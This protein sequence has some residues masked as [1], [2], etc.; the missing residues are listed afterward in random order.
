MMLLLSF[1]KQLDLQL[2]STEIMG[3]AKFI[4]TPKKNVGI[5]SLALP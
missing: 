1:Q 5:S 2:V 4:T 3:A